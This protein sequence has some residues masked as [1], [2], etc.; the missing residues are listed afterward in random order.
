M[1]HTPALA[2]AI[3][4]PHGRLR[5]CEWPRMSETRKTEKGITVAITLL[6]WQQNSLTLSVLFVS[7][8][9]ISLDTVRRRQLCLKLGRR[10]DI[11]APIDTK[12]KPRITKAHITRVI[13]TFLPIFT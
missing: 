6:N 5:S 11:D 10:Q 4:V 8:L 3:Y 2:Q 13:C 9:L 7:H 12:I 1:L